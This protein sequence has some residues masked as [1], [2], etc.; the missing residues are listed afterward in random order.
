M[1]RTAQK[2]RFCSIGP[3]AGT[4]GEDCLRLNVWTPGPNPAGRK[5]AVMVYMHGGY[6]SG[7]SGN[8]LLAY[9]GENLARQS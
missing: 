9:D 6:Y 4:R 1:C 5:R 2:T 3:A 7:G 8:D